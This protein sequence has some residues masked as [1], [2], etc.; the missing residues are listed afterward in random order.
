MFLSEEERLR[1]ELDFE[2]C[3]VKLFD[4]KGTEVKT[5]YQLIN[6]RTGNQIAVMPKSYTPY[7]NEMFA[8]KVGQI[9]KISDLQF[10]GY[11]VWKDDCRV[12][13]VFKK[14]DVEVLGHQH[15]RYIGLINSHDGSHAIKLLHNLV[16]KRCTNGLTTLRGESQFRIKHTS[17]SYDRMKIDLHN[18]LK[19]FDASLRQY[20][21]D[22]SFLDSQKINDEQLE[23]MLHQMQG[24]DAESKISSRMANIKSR[25]RQ[26][27]KIEAADLG[28]N[29][30][31]FLQGQTRFANENLIKNSGFAAFHGSA[32]D[33]NA[34]AYRV[35]MEVAYLL[36]NKQPLKIKT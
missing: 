19:L 8:E 27:Y 12:I 23:F 17:G 31:A 21:Q 28:E 14:D 7:Y 35:A 5:H 20:Q 25:L 9:S 1:Q 15:N 24:T 36:K 16:M 18:S 11:H 32:A 30:F 2:V 3:K 29:C 22:A 13:A 33:H 10:C 6:N 26:A 4:E 34:K